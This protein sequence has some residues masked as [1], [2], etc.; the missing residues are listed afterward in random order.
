MAERDLRVEL[1]RAA[2]ELIDADGVE[3]LTLRSVSARVGVS[4]QAPY[5]HFPDKRALLA[6]VAC[7]GLR[8]ERRWAREA[9]AAA[10]NPRQV[11]M[12]ILLA[13]MRLR[14]E[15][16]GTYQLAHGRIGKHEDPD[17]QREAIESFALVREAVR[18]VCAANE[19]IEVIRR[20]C[21]I[22]WG[23]VRGLAELEAMASRPALVRGEP[24]TW[25]EEGVDDL[26][27]TWTQ[28]TNTDS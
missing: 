3:A 14:R 19:D 1:L 21:M 13:H 2:S 20:R 22:L 26:L 17:L 11:L 18:D 9:I 24:R 7:E 16:P 27:R 23:L 10:S 5:L 8:T 25:L 4:R 15:R 6:A 12:A 28:T